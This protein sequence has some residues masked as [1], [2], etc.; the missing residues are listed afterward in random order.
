MFLSEINLRHLCEQFIP[1]SCYVA[2]KAK[3]GVK[4]TSGEA[5][6]ARD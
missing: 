6:L 5:E 2:Q 1:V 3:P 4:F